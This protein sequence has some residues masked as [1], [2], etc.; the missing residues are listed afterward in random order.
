ME[1]YRLQPLG[2]RLDMVGERARCREAERV[3]KG[4]NGHFPYCQCDADQ[5]G[6][7]QELFVPLVKKY[8]FEYSESDS[9]DVQQLRTTA[10]EQA[11]VAGDTWHVPSLRPRT[12][13]LTVILSG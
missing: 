13:V 5:S 3:P 2:H 8:G 1:H 11:A 10:I 12:S 6:P 9:Y 7:S 4:T